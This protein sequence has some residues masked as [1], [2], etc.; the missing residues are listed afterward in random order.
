MDQHPC[1]FPGAPSY[2]Y[3]TFTL[4]Q[5]AIPRGKS[6]SSSS[7]PDLVPIREDSPFPLCFSLWS[8]RTKTRLA[9]FTKHDKHEA[10]R[11]WRLLPVG[12]GFTRT[13]TWLLTNPQLFTL[14][15]GW[16]PHNAYLLGQNTEQVSV[17]K[18]RTNINHTIPQ[19]HP[20]AGDEGWAHWHGGMTMT[21][22]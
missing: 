19:R 12:S 6:P 8:V 5:G 22:C 15:Q 10:V 3:C 7:W 14:A 9:V 2:V 18:I 11:E 21:V 17:T 4:L 13:I 1:I 20:S 16:T